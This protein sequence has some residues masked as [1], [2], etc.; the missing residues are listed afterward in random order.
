MLL[1]TDIIGEINPMQFLHYF[2]ILIMYEKAFAVQ[3]RINVSKT[4]HEHFKFKFR[5]TICMTAYLCRNNDTLNSFNNTVSFF[6]YKV[7]I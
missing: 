6:L 5:F 7:K 2:H 1:I 3:V 4:G